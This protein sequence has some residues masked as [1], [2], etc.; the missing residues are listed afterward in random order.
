[1]P[2]T[3][4]AVSEDGLPN[5]SPV[6]E[7]LSIRQIH[8]RLQTLP[9][10]LVLLVSIA[11]I[12][13]LFASAILL[14]PENRPASVEISTPEEFAW[15]PTWTTEE[16][17]PK[18]AYVQ[19]ATN[20][21]YLCNAV[22]NFARLRRYGA[23]EDLVLIHPNEWSKGN[24][25]EATAL[26]RLRDSSPGLKMSGFDLISTSKG[27]KTWQ[28]SLT[29]FHAFALTGWK[30]VLAFDSDSLVL[31]NMDDYFLSPKA[32]IAL[33]RAYWLNEKNMDKKQVLGSHVML[34]EP[35]KARYHKI[36]DEAAQSGEFDMEVVNH[37]FGD[38]AMILPHRGLALLTGEFRATNHSKYLAP[39]ENEVWNATK[40]VSQSYLVHFSDWPL[41]KPWI[42]RTKQQWE[43]ALPECPVLD[44]KVGREGSPK[45]ADRVVWSGFYEEYD[46]EKS[47]QCKILSE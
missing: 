42:S 26:A 22:I 15:K 1:M 8:R 35:N 14:A 30:R 27:D 39:N 32:P 20:M 41:P 5:P 29:K 28:Y 7:R 13:L 21:D 2:W 46:R 45:C 33:P 38:S 23:R 43:A 44:K 12:I 17:Q 47:E 11:L 25:R 16:V 31:N 3:L 19:Y 4:D 10:R 6:R 34:I 40:E 37:L 18:F 24:S 36:M 9:R